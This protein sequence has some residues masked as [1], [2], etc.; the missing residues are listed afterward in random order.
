MYDKITSNPL[1]D[2][3]LKEHNIITKEVFEEKLKEIKNK[4]NNELNE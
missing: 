2:K 1:M 4:L 3:I